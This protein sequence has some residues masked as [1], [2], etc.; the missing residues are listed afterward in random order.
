MNNKFEGV[1]WEWGRV[2]K[3]SD[4]NLDT[5]RYFTKMFMTTPTADHLKV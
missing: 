1:I 3:L 2:K 4:K 5:V